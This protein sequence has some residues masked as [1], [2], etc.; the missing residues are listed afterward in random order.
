MAPGRALLDRGARLGAR[1]LAVA[2]AAGHGE[3]AAFRVPR[4]AVIATGDELRP[5]GAPLGPG[6]I[7]DSNSL[8]MAALAREG[9]ASVVSATRVGDDPRATRDAL[10][11]ALR[12]A[13]VL[14]ISGGV[15]VGPHDH[16]KQALAEL[17]VE[18]RFWGIAIRPGRPTWFGTRNG[19]LV[20]GLPGNPVSTIVI[21]ALLVRP[22]LAALTGADPRPGRLTA[23]LAHELPRQPNRDEAVRVRIE[24]RAEGLPLAHPCGPQASHVTTSLLGAD[25]LALIEAGEG[26]HA[27][28]AEVEVE[29]L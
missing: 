20:F 12:Q 5:P 6:E 15:S 23:L 14:T 8:A 24:R 26:V 19:T 29:L 28:G 21:H 27:A 4:V 13:D 7:H 9:G 17:G 3:L 1:E 22:A 11:A 18:Q 10:A 25:G 2:V 16:V